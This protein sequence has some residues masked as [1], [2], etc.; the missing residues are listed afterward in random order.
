MASLPV[1][2]PWFLCSI[3]SFTFK[4]PKAA[5]LLVCLLW[6]CS[7]L[8]WVWHA[9]ISLAYSYFSFG[10]SNASCTSL[11]LQVHIEESCKIKGEYWSSLHQ[12]LCFGAQV[13]MEKIKIECPD[14]QIRLWPF[15]VCFRCFFLA[16]VTAGNVHGSRLHLAQ[17]L[18]WEPE[19]LFL[20]YPLKD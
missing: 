14:I 20:L 11:W 4:C 9:I 2:L 12:W 16:V 13:E 10:I 6:S 1:L 19:K 17:W 5:A 3:H 8:H 15:V 7:V 18:M